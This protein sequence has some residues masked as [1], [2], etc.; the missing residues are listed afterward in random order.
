MAVTFNSRVDTTKKP[1]TAPALDGTSASTSTPAAPRSEHEQRGGGTF[2]GTAGAPAEQPSLAT[3][4][5]DVGGALRGPIAARIA[6]VEPKGT[7]AERLTALATHAAAHAMHEG[8]ASRT[9]LHKFGEVVGVA[10]GVIV[11]EA[12]ALAPSWNT[13]V[14]DQSGAP[15]A[16]VDGADRIGDHDILKR[17]QEVVGPKIAA[18]VKGMA[19]GAIRDLLDGLAQGASEAP[20][21][22]YRIEASVS[23]ALSRTS[24]D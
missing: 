5:V 4:G 7:D 24:K 23:D 6:Q 12:L 1:S 19:P 3:S 17:H 2:V 21:D 9:L 22:S 18:Y 8:N 13:P 16:H 20:G 15:V 14:L 11:T 10:L